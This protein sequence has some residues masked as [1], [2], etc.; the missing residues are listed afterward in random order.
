MEAPAKR[1]DAPTGSKGG[2]Q[3]K[4][5]KVGPGPFPAPT[6]ARTRLNVLHS[7]VSSAQRLLRPIAVYKHISR[8]SG[9][10]NMVLHE[11]EGGDR[12]RGLGIDPY[13][14]DDHLL[15]P[16]HATTGLRAKE[17]TACAFSSPASLPCFGDTH[18]HTHNVLIRSWGGKGS[19]WCGFSYIR[20]G[21]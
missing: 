18:T 6:G 4:K 19:M 15:G 9:L 21:R 8:F 11:L 10:R 3:F 17:G 13:M 12:S 16:M 14:G 2:P 5:K 20:R 7:D 1:K